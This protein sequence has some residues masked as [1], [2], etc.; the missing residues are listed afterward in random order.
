M[1]I[2]RGRKKLYD[3]FI[4]CCDIEYTKDGAFLDCTIKD[5]C[6]PLN[7]ALKK[8][9]IMCLLGIVFRLPYIIQTDI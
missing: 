3:L 7:N 8:S 2:Q 1:R 9:M 5:K 6:T 4:E